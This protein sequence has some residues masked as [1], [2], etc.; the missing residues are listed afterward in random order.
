MVP[1]Q[2]IKNPYI[3][4][5]GPPF[6][7]P[8]TEVTSTPSHDSKAEHE[9]PSMDMKPKLRLRTGRLPSRWR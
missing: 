7:S 9:K 1:I 8:G 2:L 4:P 6:K 3:T 5:A